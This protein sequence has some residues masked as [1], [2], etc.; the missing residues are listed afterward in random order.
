MKL[1][2]YVVVHDKGLAP[3]PFW[4]YCTLAVCTPNHMGIRLEQGDWI[5]GFSPV[6]KNNKIVYAMQVSEIISFDDYYSDPRFADKKPVVKGTWKQKCGD[7][8]YFRDDNGEWCQHSSL[9]HRDPEIIEKD[10]KHPRVFVSEYFYY[11]GD[12]M[13]TVPIE[14]CDLVWKRQGC[15]CNHNPDIALSFLRWL[16]KKFKPGVLGMPTDLIARDASDNNV[17]CSDNRVDIL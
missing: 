9:F 5:V 7:N 13:T 8:M 1:C 2:S 14:Y 15:K 6:E 3:N 10:I 4:G 11:F 16:E 17:N 12:K